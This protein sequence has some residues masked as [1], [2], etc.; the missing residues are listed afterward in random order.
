MLDNHLGILN[1]CLENKKPEFPPVC[2]HCCFSSIASAD[3]CRDMF[4]VMD[5]LENE[6]VRIPMVFACE[7][8]WCWQCLDQH[9]PECSYLCYQSNKKKWI[10]NTDLSILFSRTH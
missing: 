7:W 2:G 10:K 3:I 6:E 8:E 5:W 1:E 4:F 9:A